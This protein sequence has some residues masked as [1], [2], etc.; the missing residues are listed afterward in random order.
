MKD[1]AIEHNWIAI[2]NESH[3]ISINSITDIRIVEDDGKLFKVLLDRG[4]LQTDLEIY[5]G[6]AEECIEIM[7]EI[8]G[9]KKTE[10]GH[11]SYALKYN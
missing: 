9:W 11:Y 4:T 5:R 8:R 10:S 2:N 6:S 7:M 1:T 3:W